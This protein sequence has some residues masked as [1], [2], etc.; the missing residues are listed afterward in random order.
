[1]KHIVDVLDNGA[2]QLFVPLQDDIHIFRIIYRAPQKSVP[3]PYLHISHDIAFMALPNIE[4][5]LSVMADFNP[6]IPWIGS[7]RDML[8][9]IQA[10]AATRLPPINSPSKLA[11]RFS[12]K[13]DMD[14]TLDSQF[15]PPPTPDVINS[16]VQ[17]CVGASN[18][19]H[20]IFERFGE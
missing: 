1:M 6:N 20:L 8:R 15:M 7:A 11:S 9:I 2:N 12:R 16:L 14:T 5:L 10:S 4:G 3:Y 19:S 18:S 13:E 17:G